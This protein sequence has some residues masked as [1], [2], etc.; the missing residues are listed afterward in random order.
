MKPEFSEIPCCPMCGSE[1]DLQVIKTSSDEIIEGLLTCRECRN[2]YFIR[3]G[4]AY[5]VPPGTPAEGTYPFHIFRK[6]DE[7]KDR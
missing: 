3:N 7:E 6:Q 1:M 5:P 2:R 4:R